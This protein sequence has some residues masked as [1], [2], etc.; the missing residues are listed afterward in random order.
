MTCGTE[1]TVIGVAF[2]FTLIFIGLILAYSFVRTGVNPCK[3]GLTGTCGIKD[4][5][6]L[7]LSN[8]FGTPICNTYCR[9]LLTKGV[10]EGNN[11]LVC[12]SEFCNNLQ[13]DTKISLYCREHGVPQ[14]LKLAS[15]KKKK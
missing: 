3:N 12:E 10:T 5:D 15:I 7:C 13:I 6:A 4:M 14:K 2:I 8:R 1:Q 9:S 11:T